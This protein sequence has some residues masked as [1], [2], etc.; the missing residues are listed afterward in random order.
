MSSSS[1]P[2]SRP[3]FGWASV[4]EGSV[5]V[6]HGG[7]VSD[8]GFLNSF[9]VTF[10]NSHYQGTDVQLTEESYN[11]NLKYALQ[12]KFQD[13]TD[14]TIESIHSTGLSNGRRLKIE[15]MKIKPNTS[16][17]LHQHAGIEAI[18]VLRGSIHELRYQVL[19]N[20]GVLIVNICLDIT[21]NVHTGRSS[22]T[23]YAS[24]CQCRSKYVPLRPL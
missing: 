12:Q 21:V 20:S 19:Y 22:F 14:Q 15:L 3:G 23:P 17:R 6:I 13:E 10:A 8:V 18:F 4:A 1:N 24:G 7:Y 16:F 5:Q 9:P 2:F 11:T